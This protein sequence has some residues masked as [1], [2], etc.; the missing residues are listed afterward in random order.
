M[1]IF[2]ASFKKIFVAILLFFIF[3][4]VNSYSEVV[5]KVNVKGN[6][7][8]S[9]ETIMIFGDVAIGKNYETSDVNLLIK[10]LYE[11]NF[12]SN[13]SVKLEN[14]ILSIVVEENPII[15]SIIF[16][17]EKAKKYKEVIKGL[18]TLREK[19]SYTANSI[20]HDIN[21]IKVFYRTLG[22]YF[23]KIDT[24]IKKLKKNRVDIIFSIDKGKKAKIAKI[25]FLGD[26]K[27]RDKKLRD[28]ITSQKLGFGNLFREMYI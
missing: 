28:I 7:R 14:N 16:D 13:I 9:L 5:N 1:I 22:F 11:S 10:K 25:Y 26:K 12:F 17:G 8:I 6:A 21:Q 15:N 20:K 27:I 23:V 19:S 18:L 3:F 24:E 2:M 4:N